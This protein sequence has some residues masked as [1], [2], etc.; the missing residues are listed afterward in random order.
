MARHPVSARG[1]LALVSILSVRTRSGWLRVPAEAARGPLSLWLLAVGA[2]SALIATRFAGIG[3]RYVYNFDSLVDFHL[4]SFFH[5]TLSH[6]QL[7]LWS[8]TMG[9]GFPDYAEGKIGA[10]YPPHWLIYQLPPLPAMQIALVL[11]LV[12]LAVGTGL[13]IFRLTGSR[14]SA[15]LGA[16]AIPLVGGVVTKLEWTNMVEAFAW[17]PW[18]LLPLF[19]RGGPTRTG[20]V[21]SGL[22]FGM[23]ALTGHP[24]IWFATAAIA[25]TLTVGR[26][27]SVPSV[28][29]A[30]AFLLVGV[31]V[32]A[33]QLLPTALLL[34]LSERA[35]GLNSSDFFAYPGSIFDMLGFVFSNAFV[36]LAPTQRLDPTWYP[37]DGWGLLEAGGYVGLPMVALAAIGFQPRRMWLLAAILAAL[38]IVPLTWILRPPWLA[39]LPLLDAFRRPTRV[40]MF[41]DFL[42]VVAAGVGL[43]RLGKRDVQWRRAAWLVAIP[44]IAWVAILLVAGFAPAVFN[45]IVQSMWPNT[46][47]DRAGRA[48]AVLSTPLPVAAE[49]LFGVATVGYIRTNVRSAAAILIVAGIALVPLAVLAPPVNQMATLSAFDRSDGA[50]LTALKA[51]Q[52]HRVLTLAAPAWYD[53]TPDQIATSGI[54]DLEVHSSLNIASSDQ[55]LAA[56]RSPFDGLDVARILGVDTI[57]SFG[58][59]CPGDSPELVNDTGAEPA[60]TAL[61][62][63]LSNAL[64]PPYWLPSAD[65]SINPCANVLPFL[66]CH[67]S[68]TPVDALRDSLA[69]D[70]TTASDLSMSISVDAPKAGWVFIDRTWWP[71]WD[72]TVDDHP[73]ATY[74]AWGGQLVAV[75]GGKHLI[76]ERFVPRDVQIGLTISVLTCALAGIWA[77]RGRPRKD[78]KPQGRSRTSKRLLARRDR[79]LAVASDLG[80]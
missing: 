28:G 56:A 64:R 73:A 71:D 23:Q 1:D 66:P 41:A 53:G 42:V 51:A 4:P 9:L 16:A 35:N 24:D 40:Y 20:L 78:R 29:D 72:V 50:L 14:S 79:I 61:I 67:A 6:G 22:A 55:A 60:R 32:G 33:V 43:A 48:V 70:A 37:S 45:A 3:G 62:C 49:L 34:P 58:P 25:V 15:L 46:P 10:F 44:A 7:P 2:A 21:L 38:L 27:R 39:Q 30:A 31:G 68:F 19:R 69:V 47:V 12:L 74:E 13:L 59:T 63:H 26:G 76:E 5:D 75:A 8:S 18:V 11:H 77:C 80:P 54:D 17:L 52:P 65:V 36:H 57:V